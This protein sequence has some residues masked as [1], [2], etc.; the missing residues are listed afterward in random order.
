MNSLGVSLF[1]TF[2]SIPSSQTNWPVKKNAEVGYTSLSK[3]IKVS[4]LTLFPLNFLFLLLLSR[5]NN[6]YILKHSPEAE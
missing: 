4:K 2:D 3:F 1:R 5:Y 6:L